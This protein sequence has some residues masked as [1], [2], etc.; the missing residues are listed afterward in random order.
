MHFA[1]RRLRHRG[2]PL[3]KHEWINGPAAVGDLRVEQIR[4]DEL[5]RYLRIARVID[6]RRPRDPDQ[7]PPLYDPGLIAMSPQ[8]FSLAGFERIDGVAVVQSWLVT[9][10][11]R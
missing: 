10:P 5:R 9:L 2:R 3:P 6:V 4:D 11:G 7:L 1:V 8:A